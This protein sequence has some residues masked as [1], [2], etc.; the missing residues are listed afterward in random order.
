MRSRWLKR[1]FRLSICAAALFSLSYCALL[2]VVWNGRTEVV[3]VST[4]L[5]ERRNVTIFGSSVRQPSVTIYSLDGEKYRHG[6][7]P[8]AHAQLMAWLSNA[9]P[10]IFVAIHDH[11]GRDKDFRPARVK[12][13]YWRPKIS[14]RGPA[15]DVFLLEELRAVIKRRF[16]RGGNQYLFGHSLGGFYALDMASRQTKHGFAGIYA[17][18]PTFSHDLSLLD[19][20]NNSCENSSSIYANIGLESGRDTDVFT[21]ATV[22]ANRSDECRSKITVDEHF[23]MIHGLVMLTGQ[24]SALRQIY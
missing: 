19:R 9:P 15:F 21:Q 4:A 1:F 8:A 20:L 10:P 13:A 24:V 6:L 11:G 7:I 17:F 5:N 2:Y 14:G 18:S 12:P 3:V 16:G 22:A 23:G